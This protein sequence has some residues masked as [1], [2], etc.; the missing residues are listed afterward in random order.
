VVEVRCP[1]CLTE[2]HH[3]GDGR[4]TA[5]GTPEWISYY[6]RTKRKKWAGQKLAL[7]EG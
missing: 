1:N 3:H 6:W 5:T 4:E 7:P 2:I